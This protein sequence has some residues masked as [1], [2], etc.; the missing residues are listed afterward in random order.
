M[1]RLTTAITVRDNARQLA[2]TQMAIIEAQSR[3][4]AKYEQEISDQKAREASERVKTLEKAK[5]DRRK[6]REQSARKAAQD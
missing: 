4:I 3:V 2:E 5:A 1:Q 6:F